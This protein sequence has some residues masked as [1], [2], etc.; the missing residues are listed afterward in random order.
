MDAY[1]HLRC[2]GGAANRERGAETDRQTDRERESERASERERERESQEAP[3]ASANR[4]PCAV[5]N[6]AS[7]LGL[8]QRA[9]PFRVSIVCVHAFMPSVSEDRHARLL[10]ERERGREGRRGRRGGAA[11]DHRCRARRQ[12]LYQRS[13]VRRTHPSHRRLTGEEMHV[14]RR[15]SRC[16]PRARLGFSVDVSAVVMQGGARGNGG[17]RA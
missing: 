2:R 4:H 1:V 3:A 16:R 8:S 13:H 5:S 7:G 10:E 17:R 14:H 9:V 15:W 6:V 11:G 12:E